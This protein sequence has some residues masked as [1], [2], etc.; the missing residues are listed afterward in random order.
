MAFDTPP[1][2][3]N[4]VFVARGLF[5]DIVTDDAARTSRLALE[6]DNAGGCSCALE[7]T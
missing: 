6:K 2:S 1:L 3:V 5:A 4:R 7:T